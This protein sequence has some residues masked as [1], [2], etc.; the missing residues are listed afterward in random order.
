[1]TDMEFLHSK[2][3]FVAQDHD[4]QDCIGYLRFQILRHVEGSKNDCAARHGKLA[5]AVKAPFLLGKVLLKHCP[6]DVLAV[7][8]RWKILLFRMLACLLLCRTKVETGASKIFSSSNMYRS[9]YLCK[10]MERQLLCVNL[11]SDCCQA[12]HE[13]R[14]LSCIDREHV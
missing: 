8:S 6:R 4:S 1:M 13:T 2:V 10:S 14:I 11:V 12:S 5:S 3:F 9:M 7:Y